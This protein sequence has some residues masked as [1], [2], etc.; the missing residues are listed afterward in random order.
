M[1][2]FH[3]TEFP[4]I[5]ISPGFRYLK[6]FS[7]NKTHHFGV[8]SRNYCS[9][10]LFTSLFPPFLFFFEKNISWILN[11]RMNGKDFQLEEE[12]LLLHWPLVRNRHQCTFMLCEWPTIKLQPLGIKLLE[13]FTRHVL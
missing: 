3:K 8:R 13:T 9:Q 1:D 10:F 11:K 6:P 12:G 5:I 2:C 4:H 7:F